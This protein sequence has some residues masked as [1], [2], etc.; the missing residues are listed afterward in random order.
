M[1]QQLPY[2]PQPPQQYLQKPPQ[3]SNLTPTINNQKPT[4]DNREL[5]TDNQKKDK[6]TKGIWMMDAGTSRPS[7][8]TPTTYNLTINPILFHKLATQTHPVTDQP[9]VS[10]IIP[11]Y[12]HA[13]IIDEALDTVFAQTSYMR[14]SL[15]R[16]GKGIFQIS[17]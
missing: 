1:L 17:R 7:H 6:R 4:S 16:T 15:W 3:T 14:H 9:L 8:L 13:Y 12:K 5:T 10:I 2:P 11:T